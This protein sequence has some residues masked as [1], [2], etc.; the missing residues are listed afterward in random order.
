MAENRLLPRVRRAYERDGLDGVWDFCVE[1]DGPHGKAKRFAAAERF[2]EHRRDEAEGDDRERW[3]NARRIYARA[4]DKWEHEWERQNPPDTSPQW[5]ATIQVAELLYHAPG[6]HVHFASPER[7]KLI[8]IG[9][10]AQARGLRV[11][12]F[13]PFDVT[14]DLHARCVSWHYRDPD[15]PWTPVCYSAAHMRLGGDWGLA[16]DLNDLDGGS[17]QEYAFYLELRRRYA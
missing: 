9:R 11:G 8:A 14:E 10:I 4:R 3:A 17:D 6:P 2:A 7:D 13:P 12:E 1:P 16:M 15:R 5:P